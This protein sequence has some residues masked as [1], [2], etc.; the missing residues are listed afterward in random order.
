MCGFHFAAQMTMQSQR[1]VAWKLWWC[2]A[3]NY[4]LTKYTAQAAHNKRHFRLNV[5]V[6]VCVPAQRVI[7]STRLCLLAREGKIDDARHCGNKLSIYVTRH[8]RRIKI[9][10]SRWRFP[11]GDSRAETQHTR[12]ICVAFSKTHT[13]G[14]H[15]RESK[16]A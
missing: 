14:R 9:A 4:V 2:A 6:C 12:A 3:R 13:P 16:I 1:I 8:L 15:I 10:F 11:L 7:N 5:C